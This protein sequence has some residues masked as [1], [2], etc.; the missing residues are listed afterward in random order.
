M[1]KFDK[2][3][4]EE[5][6]KITKQGNFRKN[7]QTKYKGICK[8][9]N[10]EFLGIK[11]QIYCSNKCSSNDRPLLKIQYNTLLK[12]F[13]D[14]G[15]KVITTEEEWNNK[16]TN[17]NYFKVKF[18][19]PNSHKHSMTY[20]NF[21]RGQRCGLCAKNAPVKWIDV[22]N[23]FEKKKGWTVLT[24]ENEWNI[25]YRDKIKFQCDKKHIYS[26]TYTSLNHTNFGCPYCNNNVK[27]KFKDIKKWFE[28]ENWTVLT[29]ENE[30][31]SQNKTP[32]DCICPNGHRQ[33][34]NIRKWRMG[35]RCPY[36]ITSGP[37]LELKKFL[38]KE[39]I[40]FIEN[41]RHIGMELDIWIPSLKKAIEFNG[42][43]WHCNPDK[44]E[45][46]YFHKHKDLYAYQIWERDNKKK[47]LCE[48]KDIDLM[49]IW[50][51]DWKNNKDMCK[52]SI[53]EWL[54]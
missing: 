41:D 14:N 8:E 30:Y 6:W 7:G 11:N 50:E 48:E 21:Y 9:C 26:Y 34:K 5:G 45:D 27:I 25:A 32:I 37:E 51:S 18:I 29:K 4:I 19:C 44:Y 12:L 16:T 17:T 10:K 24:K 23:L 1:T 20:S 43:Y 52:K 42:D 33:T 35:R 13:N 28:D 38:K 49:F 39:N 46:N 31:I 22:I 54:K 40:E 15:Y 36:C 47:L 3:K 2:Q 53:L